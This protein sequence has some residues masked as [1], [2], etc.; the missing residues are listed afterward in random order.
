VPPELSVTLQVTAL[1][2]VPVTVAVNV[3]VASRKTVAVLGLT[4]TMT[5]GGGGGA[6]GGKVV[7]RLPHALRRPSAKTKSAAG[8]EDFMWPSQ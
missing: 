1:L 3:C 2:V 5:S 8:I 6:G 7:E 4:L